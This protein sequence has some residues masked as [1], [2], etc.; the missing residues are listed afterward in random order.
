MYKN[1]SSLF[2][3]FY[4]I[5]LPCNIFSYIY[6]ISIYYNPIT[7][8]TCYIFS[9]IHN[10]GTVEQ[11][12]AQM[13]HF[14]QSVLPKL[15]SSQEPSEYSSRVG[16]YS[17]ALH[18]SD[19]CKFENYEDLIDSIKPIFTRRENMNPT[20]IG[21]ELPI[22][23]RQYLDD[24]RLQY[25]NLLDTDS[26]GFSPLNNSN[27]IYFKNIDPRL[28]IESCRAVFLSPSHSSSGKKKNHCTLKKST[29]KEEQLASLHDILSMISRIID[30]ALLIN[31][32]SNL[33]Q[34][35]R[36]SIYYEIIRNL[37]RD[38]SKLRQ[39]LAQKAL[40]ENCD[41]KE[42]N[43]IKSYIPLFEE[44]LGNSIE[45][46]INQNIT[47]FDNKSEI[48]QQ[49]IY[50]DKFLSETVDIV[51]LSELC[52]TDAPD[53]AI[54]L[55]GD[56]HAKKLETNLQKLGYNLVYKSTCEDVEF[57]LNLTLS[58]ENIFQINR[59]FDS[60]GQFLASKLTEISKF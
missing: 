38:I 42:I 59:E 39:L 41:R 5:T 27:L 31:S 35:V 1:F 43:K 19:F 2:F 29:E 20:W 44:V 32:D 13:R 25:Q 15:P 3:F 37:S 47:E 28:P 53:N 10:L 34:N 52:S 57:F 22:M 12:K 24:I 33:N 50:D 16:I 51:V 55:L 17:E 18:F 46:F 40:L 21:I 26:Y 36:I 56:S 4:I 58:E 11:N 23:L 45:I 54:I 14:F 8:K 49:I 7:L 9:D 48:I 60:V 6:R 30:N